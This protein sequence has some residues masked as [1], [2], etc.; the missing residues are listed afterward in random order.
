MTS[1][2]HI[3]FI[4]F[5][6][7]LS[8]DQLDE[9]IQASK[10]LGFADGYDRERARISD[11]TLCEFLRAPITGTITEVPNIGAATAKVLAKGTDP[12][13]NSY[14]LIG[15]YISLKTNDPETNEPID[16]DS[17]CDK[18]WHWLKMKGVTTNRDGI[19]LAIAE[20]TNTMLPGIY[21]EM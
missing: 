20:K 21:E 5:T 16:C 6:K 19:V 13:L 12:I 7:T 15:K 11:D 14:Q 8:E 1:S 10:S 2:K 18:F 17:H 9:L 4:A 3:Q